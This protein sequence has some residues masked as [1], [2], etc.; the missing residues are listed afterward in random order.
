V[1]NSNKKLQLYSL[2]ASYNLQSVVDFPTR[3]IN[4]SWTAIDNIFI[5]KHKN[6]DFSIQS[7]PNRLSDHDAQTLTLNVIKIQN[8]LLIT[9]QEE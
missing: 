4:S 9:S 2:L 5:N 8:L 7:C 3:I 1:E 6:V